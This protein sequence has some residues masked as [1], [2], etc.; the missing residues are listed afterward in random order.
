MIARTFTSSVFH[1]T[2][3]QHF[4]YEVHH[5]TGL[6]TVMVNRLSSLSLSLRYV[7][8]FLYAVN[9]I[10]NSILM[11]WNLTKIIIKIVRVKHSRRV[12][13]ES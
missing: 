8:F 1:G 6:S 9:A 5:Q 10:E 7:F 13:N 2:Y 12:R 3:F 4:L 11:V